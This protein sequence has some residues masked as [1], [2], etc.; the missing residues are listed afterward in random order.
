[1]VSITENG[2]ISRLLDRTTILIFDDI[3]ST[4]AEVA[5]G[6]AVNSIARPGDIVSAGA[7]DICLDGSFL[8]PEA[9]H[10]SV[11]PTG[12]SLNVARVT[13]ARA[14]AMSISSRRW[15]RSS[16]ENCALIPGL[17]VGGRGQDQARGRPI[18]MRSGPS[19]SDAAHRQNSNPVRWL[20]CW[21]GPVFADGYNWWR[22]RH[23]D[24]IGWTVESGDCE[25]WIV[26]VGGRVTG[27]SI[28][29]SGSGGA[30]QGGGHLGYGDRGAGYLDNNKF[31]DDYKFEARAGD[32]IT[33]SMEKISGDL[34][35]ALR[36]Y[37]SAGQELAFDDDGGGGTNALVSDFQIPADG[38]Y[39]IHALRLREGQA[40]Q[41]DL[42]LTGQAAAPA[43]AAQAQSP[44]YGYT[45]TGFLNDNNFFGD[46]KFD[47]RADDRVTISMAA[48]SGN[49][50]PAIRL[51]SSNGQELAYDNDGGSGANA[52]IADFPIPAD[53]E[54]TIH[55]LRLHAGQAGEYELRLSGSSPPEA[56]AA[57]ESSAG[58]E[59][60]PA[61]PIRVGGACTLADA[62]VAANEDRAVGGCPAGDGADTI[63]LTGDIVLGAS[64]PE[65]TA[66]IFIDG[67]GFT[68]SGDSQYR[69]FVVGGGAHVV[70]DRL[71]LANG[72]GDW[73]GGASFS[74]MEIPS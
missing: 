69:I 35:P 47:A 18:N 8:V 50:D 37:S 9:A 73:D 36:L 52:L 60:A 40:G 51:Y 59:P 65:I 55:A 43:P 26:P 44:D 22:V 66:D 70:I 25:Y 30:L 16:G 1:M 4:Y 7:A 3:E 57:A 20:M 23:G 54:Y 74:C 49:L 39:T 6:S 2:S 64:L 58:Q 38:E 17:Q 67:S 68:I 71:T 53:G 29:S 19:L 48:T 15:S 34:D 46:Y 5:F 42:R 62:I 14:K 41:Y 72:S 45:V 28:A 10:A 13:C 31:F 21:L 11:T 56:T 61:G 12:I 27:G 63:L 33:I 24:F 32:L